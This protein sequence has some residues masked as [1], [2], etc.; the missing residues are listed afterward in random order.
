MASPF[1]LAQPLQGPACP[2]CSPDLLPT[3][4]L[5]LGR[6][7]IFTLCQPLSAWKP[8]S[9]IPQQ[10]IC[11]FHGLALLPNAGQSQRRKGQVAAPGG[12]VCDLNALWP[13]LGASPIA[14]RAADSSHP[15]TPPASP[16]PSWQIHR[17]WPCLLS[18]HTK[19]KRTKTPCPSLLERKLKFCRFVYIPC[20]ALNALASVLGSVIY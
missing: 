19:A 11:K 14:T 13:C 17:P 20:M 5:L 2:L 6:R 16:D 7:F 15:R 3:A 4:A 1:S 8:P 12:S 18:T 10:A 9:P